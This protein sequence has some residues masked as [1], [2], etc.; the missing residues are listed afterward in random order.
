MKLSPRRKE[1]IVTHATTF[2][3]LFSPFPVRGFVLKNRIVSTSHDAH[4]GVNGL[5]TDRYVR[6][7]VEK[8]KGGAA[9]VQAFG[10]TSV[11]PTSPGG[12]GNINNWDDSIIP[13][14][15]TLAEQV[16]AHG[17]IITCQLVHRGRRATS[18]VTRMPLLAPTDQPNERTG[19]TPR[20]MSH[21]DIKMVIDAYA[22]AAER[23]CRAGFDGVEI[24]MF[25]DML[26]DEFL[27]PTVNTR[28]DEY[29][30]TFEHRQRFPTE[31]L[32][33]VREPIGRDRLL[34]VRLSGDDFLPDELH[35]SERISVARQ[36]EALDTVDLFSTT[37]VS[38]DILP[39]H[40]THVP[41][42]HIPHGVYLPLARA[43]KA[44]LPP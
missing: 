10:T 25:G 12:S 44:Q 26:P 5:P 7:H 2:P 34:I 32:V 24:A 43:F 1:Q 29:G 42:S 19:E 23:T 13:P 33:A 14:F 9:M 22:A 4:F 27:S 39:G 18:A 40:P 20:A 15:R 16:H 21:G 11:H 30:G 37:C 41:S 38:L 35:L 36:S 3:R 6:Y 17:A 8:A 28:T 31:L